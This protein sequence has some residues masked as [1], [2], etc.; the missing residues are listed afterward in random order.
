MRVDMRGDMWGGASRRNALADNFK[1]GRINAEPAGAQ[2]LTD[3]PNRP[4][5][6]FIARQIVADSAGP[7]TKKCLQLRPSTQRGDNGLNIMFFHEIT[8]T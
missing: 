3:R 1:A 8:N 4:L 2:C 7:D 5:R 6:Q